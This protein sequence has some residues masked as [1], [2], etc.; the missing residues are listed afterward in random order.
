MTSTFP[1]AWN[2]WM[3]LTSSPNSMSVESILTTAAPSREVGSEWILGSE[4][5][6]DCASS[7]HHQGATCIVKKTDALHNTREHG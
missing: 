3:R 6:Q 7:G 5:P 4:R 1:S 2:G